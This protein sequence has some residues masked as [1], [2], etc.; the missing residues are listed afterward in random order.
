M[1]VSHS[2][3]FCSAFL[4]FQTSPKCFSHIIL[5]FFCFFSRFC[6]CSSYFP[7][8]SFHFCISSSLLNELSRFQLILSLASS[9]PL[10]IFLSFCFQ[11]LSFSFLMHTSHSDCFF[12]HPICFQPFSKNFSTLFYQFCSW[13]F[14]LFILAFTFI[15]SVSFLDLF[16]ASDCLCRRFFC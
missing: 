10:L 15:V 8:F 12:Y 4:M 11:P 5:I 6:S 14:K 9:I 16:T 13:P 7:S 1:H 3:C 2:F